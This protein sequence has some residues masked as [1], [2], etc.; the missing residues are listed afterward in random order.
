MIIS[1]GMEFPVSSTLKLVLKE[2]LYLFLNL[3]LTPVL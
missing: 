2:L 1:F 3:I